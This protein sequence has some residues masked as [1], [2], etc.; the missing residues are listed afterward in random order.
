MDGTKLTKQQAVFS[1][2][3]K[4]RTKTYLWRRVAQVKR[5][6]KKLKQI[7]NQPRNNENHLKTEIWD[8]IILWLKYIGM[9]T[10]YAII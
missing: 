9:L 5:N 6:H 7:V 1:K 10:I 2:V 4:R 3:T 8:N